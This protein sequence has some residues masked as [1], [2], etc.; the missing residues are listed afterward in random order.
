MP[1]KKISRDLP[2][3]PAKRDLDDAPHKTDRLTEILRR[4]ALRNQ[5]SQ[6]RAFYSVRQVAGSFHVTLSTASRAYRDLEREGLLTRVPGSK[7]LLQGRRYDRRLEVRAFVGLP[8]SLSSFVTI[9]AYRNFF[10]KIRRELR[11]RGFATAMVFCE[12]DETRT[13]ELSERLKA[14]EVD[15]VIWFQPPREAAKS[16]PWLSD[17]GIRVVGVAHEEF[18][19]IPCRY[20]VR[21]DQG[22]A[23]LLLQWKEQYGID[24]VTLAQP[25]EGK[26]SSLDEILHDVLD[27]FA[28]KWSA[29]IF[30]GTG[31]ESFVRALQS[32]TTGGII[33]SS[34]QLASQLC[35]R[36]PDTVADL[37]QIRR[38]ALLNGPVSMPFARVPNVNVD[39]VVVDWQRV[40]EKIVDDLIT[41]EAFQNG[42]T[43]IFEAEAKLR[44]PLSEF[45]HS[46]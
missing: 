17:L 19:A 36:T 7:T 6:P 11:L 34:S 9:Q 21:R 45:A 28:I 22:I 39:I 29:A 15:T 20:Q 43:R 4:V 33:F 1:R 3:L 32:T 5:R 27:D 41:Q 46:I 26:L 25:R 38:V 10:I 16:T 12:K 18:P 37:L 40:A 44:V 24:H 30:D 14:Y 23:D 2:P 35:F 13:A 8:A 31:S 42:R